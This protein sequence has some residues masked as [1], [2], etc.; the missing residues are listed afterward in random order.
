MP[1]K[2]RLLAIVV[3][4]CFATACGPLRLDDTPQIRGTLVAVNSKSIGIRHK[5]GA[6]YYVD[7]TPDTRI[8]DSRRPG[9]AMLCPGRR[10]TVLLAGNRR[11]VASSI[12]LWSGDCK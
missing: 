3:T 9:P 2:Y 12:T 5:T 4:G 7:V 11:F 6:T 8:V 1:C 10:A